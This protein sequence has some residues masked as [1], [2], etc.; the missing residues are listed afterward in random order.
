[1]KLSNSLKSIVAGFGLVLASQA[2]ASVTC[3]PG[4]TPH[5]CSPP[6]GGIL[7][8]RGQVNPNVYT[9][10]FVSFVASA[11]STNLSFAM[12]EDP[13]FLR[14]DDI[15]VTARGSALN[16]VTN[17]GFEGGTYT[18][19]D[20]TA[21]P[22]G[23]IYL[24][25]FNAGANGR[26]NSAQPHSGSFNYYDGSVLAYDTITQALATTIG[27]TYD[28]S[29]WL[30]DGRSAFWNDAINVVVYAG[31]VPTLNPTPPSGVPEPESIALLGLGLA[32]LGLARRRKQA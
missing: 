3:L 32:G 25:E 24:N 23:W 15:V 31:L 6:V 9:Q 2:M 19:P 27:A 12:R 30:V 14:L 10:Y 29:F 21:Q 4:D 17:G 20:G 8:L 7:D 11:T 5:D 26:V 1:M 22:N 18:A 16:L 13:S 28:I